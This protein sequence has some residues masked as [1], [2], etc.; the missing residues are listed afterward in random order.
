[1]QREG[2]LP[3]LGEYRSAAQSQAMPKVKDGRK[4]SLKCD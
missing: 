1:M 4:Q 2:S 3:S